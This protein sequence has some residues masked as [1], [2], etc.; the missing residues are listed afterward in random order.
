MFLPG[1]IPT[2][3]DAIDVSNFC[4]E[5]YSEDGRRGGGS[6]KMTDVG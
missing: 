1:S 5:K 2:E 4:N 3:K 6:D